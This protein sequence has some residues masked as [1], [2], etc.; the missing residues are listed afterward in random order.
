MQLVE[1]RLYDFPMV[2]DAEN[3]FERMVAGAVAGLTYFAR[4]ACATVTARRIISSS[5]RSESCLP[6]SV[7]TS[8][9]ASGLR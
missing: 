5:E 2:K 4:A 6:S 1:R 7:L 9:R 3:G 8:S